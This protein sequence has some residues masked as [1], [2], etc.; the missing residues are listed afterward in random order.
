MPPSITRDTGMDALVHAIE[1]FVNV[2]AWP[3]S[4]ALSLKAIEM[5]GANLR[6]AVYNGNCLAAR[7]AMLAAS[8]TAGFAFHNT[9]LTLV[10]AITTP[11]QGVFEMPHGACNAIVLPYAMEFMLPG[12]V[13]KYA[14][15]ATAMGE[16]VVG[17]APHAAAERAIVA[18]KQLM[19]D[20]GVPKGLA[21]FHVTAD[22]FP[23][24]AEKAA[25]SFMIALAPR[26]ATAVDIQAILRQ[27]L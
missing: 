19:A 17:L 23:A 16:S 7:D 5:I 6:T 14:R 11:L 9:R 18:V 1:S 8:L 24:I 3:A 25:A 4:E 22:A 12:A 21:A 10:H 2:N 13:D 27:S 26:R 20:I 15:I